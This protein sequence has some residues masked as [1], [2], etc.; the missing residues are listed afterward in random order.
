MF[1]KRN[2]E[3]ALE[4]IRQLHDGDYIA[5]DFETSDRFE[6]I[7]SIGVASF[8]DG[9]LLGYA[10]QLVNPECR[11]DEVNIG[12]NEI[13]PEMVKNEDNFP[14]VWSNWFGDLI[15]NKF[16]V[17]HNASFDIRLIK[18]TCD[19]YGLPTVNFKFYCTLKIAESIWPELE[20]HKLDTLARANKISFHHHHAEDDAIAAGKIFALEMR[21][22][23]ECLNPDIFDREHWP[24]DIFPDHYVN[25]SKHLLDPKT[26]LLIPDHVGNKLPAIGS[27][28]YS[29][30]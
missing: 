2:N 21:Q 27:D 1:G 23:T 9:N 15:N 14:T 30:L 29:K 18:E 22:F 16:V 11:F 28:E 10:K 19:R 25:M 6:G 20:N 5:V 3:D 13:T 12:I 7:C 8:K 4:I 17:A 26:S 24:A